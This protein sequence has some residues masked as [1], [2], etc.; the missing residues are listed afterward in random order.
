[1]GECST[2]M[3]PHIRGALLAALVGALTGAA[4]LA[5][6]F[7]ADPVV[8][9]EFDRDLRG[10][11]SGF[12]G[13]ERTER[14][15]FAWSRASSA[16]RLPGLA[17]EHGWDC[18]VR[19]RGGRPPGL[20]QP[21]VQVEVDGIGLATHEATND[22]QDVP[23]AVPA[24]PGR[25][26]LTLTIAS[27]PVFVPSADD[28]RQLGVQVDRIRCTPQS[29]AIVMPP[30][31]ALVTAVVSGAAFGA[32]FGLVFPSAL[33]AAAAAMLLA[34]VQAVPLAAGPAAFHA[35]QGCALEVALW[36]AGLLAVTATTLR[37]LRPARLSVPAGVALAF[38]AAALFLQLLALLHPLKDPVDVVFHA[39]RFQGVLA[40]NYFFTQPMPSGVHFPYAIALY[41]FAAPWSVFTPD[42]ALLLR[43]VVSAWHAL[44]GLVLYAVVARAW[45]DGAM[46]AAAVVFFHL[47]P[48]PYEVI[49]NANMTYAFGASVAIVT[50]GALAFWRLGLLQALAVFVLAAIGFLSH[51]AVFPLLLTAMLFTA[52]LFWWSRSAVL[53]PA[54]TWVA[55]IALAAAVFSVSIYY[56]RFMDSYRS[57]E[58]ARGATVQ[59]NTAAPADAPAMVPRAVRAARA[60]S[61]LRADFGWP[62]L[63]LA[64]AGAW[65]LRTQPRDDR[66]KLLVGSV[67]ATYLVF[68]LFALAAPV[69]AGMQRYADEF[70][71]RVDYATAP[72]VVTLAALGLVWCW[73]SGALLRWGAALVT[74][75]AVSLGAREWIAWLQ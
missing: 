38:T 53:R 36:I 16:V 37:H 45:R 67:G 51:V 3:L 26:G 32:A 65:R 5:S 12:H 20:P 69:K 24:R 29:G 57:L 68:V 52:G 58:N 2:E 11:F 25:P 10:T 47:V 64:A 63:L 39:H 56:V 55:A 8:A 59:Q 49:G 27:S 73:R 23:V 66:V 43:I 44:A 22:Y 61:L 28:P 19:V 60:L 7:L 15:S 18:E 6:A 9:L 72:A 42:Y 30:R 71:S 4:S 54:A 21:V 46:A 31:G 33:L 35:Y 75:G 48:L 70:I 50:L 14:E 17:R 40:G 74:A 34:M 1:M 41:V 13:V 62:L